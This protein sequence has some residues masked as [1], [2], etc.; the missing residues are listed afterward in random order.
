MQPI[1]FQE[2]NV[3]SLINMF[4]KSNRVLLADETGL[5]KTMTTVL[6]IAAL[7]YKKKIKNINIINDK[8]NV[9]YICS[10][11]R[12]ARKNMRE[13]C[14][15]LSDK[16]NFEKAS[17]LIG[18]KSNINNDKII[19][20]RN[21]VK[22]MSVKDGQRLSLKMESFNSYIQIYN[23]TPDTS[24]RRSG[25]VAALGTEDEYK[26]LMKDK[27]TSDM[28]CNKCQKKIEAEYPDKKIEEIIKEFETKKIDLNIFEEECKCKDNFIKKFSL[29]RK[30]KVEENFKNHINPKPDLIV[31]DEYQSY[32]DI[33]PVG[34]LKNKDETTT[35]SDILEIFDKEE[36]KTK[37]L[38]LSAT[39]YQ[40]Q[41]EEPDKFSDFKG[42]LLFLCNG[43][44]NNKLIQSFE[45]YTE[46]LYDDKCD[47]NVL[48]DSKDDFEKS[49]RKFCRRNQRLD[50]FDKPSDSLFA[51]PEIKNQS[52]YINALKAEMISRKQAGEIRKKYP[53]ISKSGNKD[54]K[55]ILDIQMER[56]TAWG[57]SF[58]KDY[59]Y[60][61]K[62]I[63][64]EVKKK[65]NL[66]I[67]S[68]DISEGSGSEQCN[69]S[70]LEDNIKKENESKSDSVNKT[71]LNCKRLFNVGKPEKLIDVKNWP[72]FKA[73]A[74]RY[75]ST[76]TY[77][78]EPYAKE[79]RIPPLYDCIWFP[80]SAPDHEPEPESPYHAFFKEAPSKTIAFCH[81]KM[82]T[83][84]IAALISVE[85]AATKGGGTLDFSDDRDYLCNP[86]KEGLSDKMEHPFTAAFNAL[87]QI[88][89]ND[90]KLNK[91]DMEYWSKIIA[92]ELMEYFER[93]EVKAVL[94]RVGVRNRDDL[95]RYCY[96]GNLTAV[97]RE[98]MSTKRLSLGYNK[99]IAYVASKTPN[100]KKMKPQE[101]LERI[102]SLAWDEMI[103]DNPQKILDD[104]LRNGF[105]TDFV[106]K[107]KEPYDGLRN[108]IPDGFEKARIAAWKT[109]FAYQLK[110]GD[111]PLDIETRFIDAV[112]DAI[113]R[114]K[115]S[116]PQECADLNKRKKYQKKLPAY[117]KGIQ[118][119]S[120]ESFIFKEKSYESLVVNKGNG[121][122]S[123]SLGR[124]HN[125]Y[126]GNIDPNNL[127]DIKTYFDYCV[128][129]RIDHLLGKKTKSN[130]TNDG[131]IDQGLFKG[132]E[133]FTGDIWDYLDDKYD[134]HILDFMPDMHV[135][136][137]YKTGK[138]VKCG[139]IK[140]GFSSRYTPEIQDANDH[141]D[142]GAEKVMNAFNSPFYPF[143]LAVTDTA[144][145]GLNF[146]TYCRRLIHLNI[147][148]RPA[149][150][151]QREGRVDR[152]HSLV[153]RQRLANFAKLKGYK[154]DNWDEA[155]KWMKN[156]CFS[157]NQNG[158]KPDWYIDGKDG[159]PKI[160][161]YYLVNSGTD[162]PIKQKDIEHD[163]ALYKRMLGSFLEDELEKRLELRYPGQDISCLRLKLI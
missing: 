42:I 76:E 118:A 79:H 86:L 62:V 91:S 100:W 150:L 59:E 29:A 75:L 117:I 131:F 121:N 125:F 88:K 8:F 16:K 103:N 134:E 102:Y 72:N 108:G 83:R 35:I 156:N 54:N 74:I 85:A 14:E 101:R 3:K 43:D 162:D 26:A 129:T 138:D 49:L 57:Y 77:T 46:C 24:F 84:S 137:D 4:D 58:S 114:Y 93:D 30:E 71:G 37:V 66:L 158:M 154:I 159:D 142:K 80:A 99:V 107:N 123:Y 23:A 28:F 65:E 161:K 120:L 39:P 36:L 78:D 22:S 133:G 145:E 63:Y 10:N 61:K 9:L 25:S 20:P 136:I 144:K 7:A 51:N 110:F 95:M 139:R 112:I 104:I 141:N 105:K 70:M 67:Q 155:W 127:K 64:D 12:I 81:Y 119:N 41:T 27:I 143:V 55:S 160:E 19:I 163:A 48:I 82:T 147:P 109:W 56:D 126:S 21:L 146:H 96:N 97:L 98:Y 13:L 94:T 140:L 33:L 115:R 149:V 92:T 157:L 45:K 148:D 47:F 153:L 1:K 5:G 122:T 106:D 34:E 132:Y 90:V 38:M 6:V 52:N 111:I 18:I 151:I 69:Q 40:S 68:N 89:L 124:Y 44:K 113:K 60:R 31:L 2:E 32:E 116:F 130:L 11:D 73:Q 50:V 128:R 17:E 15:E 135:C 152:Y 87:K 53:E